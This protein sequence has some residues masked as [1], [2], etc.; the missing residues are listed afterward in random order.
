M[1]PKAGAATSSQDFLDALNTFQ[2]YIDNELS[3]A[4]SVAKEGGFGQAAEN[5]RKGATYTMIGQA[6]TQAARIPPTVVT[7]VDDVPLGTIGEA[8]EYGA[9]I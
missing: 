3:G 8:Q 7:P 9:G 6:E 2:S 4:M 5:T 1:I